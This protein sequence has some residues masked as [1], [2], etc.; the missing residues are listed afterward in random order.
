MAERYNLGFE[1]IW[2]ILP[3]FC[4]REEMPISCWRTIEQNCF[5]FY[6]KFENIFQNQL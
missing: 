2:I 6:Y 3:S 5:Y 4:R 1:D